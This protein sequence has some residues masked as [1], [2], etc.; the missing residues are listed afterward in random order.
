M[1]LHLNRFAHKDLLK[2]VAAYASGGREG[3]KLQSSGQ[4]QGLLAQLPR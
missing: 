2:A 1:S 3:L 4:A